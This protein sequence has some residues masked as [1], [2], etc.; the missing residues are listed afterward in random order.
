MP[1]L[2]DTGTNWVRRRPTLPAP[3]PVLDQTLFD[4]VGVGFGLVHLVHG[5]DQRHASRN[6]ACSTASTVCGMTPSS[7]ATTSTTMSVSLAPRAR[8]AVNAA[9]PGV[10]RKLMTPFGVVDM[11]GT[12]VL[13]DAA[14]FA[15]GDLG[16][17]D[18]VEQRSL[19][20]ID[21]PHDGHD[22]RTRFLVAA[23]GFGM[24][25]QRRFGIVVTGPYGLVAQFLDDEHG[26]VVIDGLIDRGHDTHLEQRFDHVRPLDRHLRGEVGDDHRVAQRN[27]THDRCG[28]VWQNRVD[29]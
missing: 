11:I 10:S 16:T 14:G 13:G 26:R 7:A 19:A 15:G 21:V 6:A 24:R 23:I 4:V 12:D 25:D 2:A 27:F 5:D 1:V 20:V 18:V 29:P 28:S 22:R 17:A 8:M 3:L 9:W